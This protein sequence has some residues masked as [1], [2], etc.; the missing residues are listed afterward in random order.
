L[1]LAF[2][3]AFWAL[4][5]LGY[6]LEVV[7]FIGVIILIGMVVN[8]GIVMVDHVNNLRRDGMS[9]VEAILEGCGDRLR[10]ILMTTITTVFGLAP[11]ALSQFTVAGIYVDSMAVAIIGGLASSTIFTLIALPVW[12]T[13]LEDIGSVLARSLPRRRRDRPLATARPRGVLAD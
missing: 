12:Y 8:N 2:F 5:L 3:G 9:R 4:W 6:R 7:A 1:P 10:P 13:T 11:L